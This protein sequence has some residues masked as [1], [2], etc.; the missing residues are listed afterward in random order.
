MKFNLEL[1]LSGT[2][3]TIPDF[4]TENSARMAGMFLQVCHP[5]IQ[6]FEIKEKR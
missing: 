3:V 5:S 2:K 4:E 6:L 1:F